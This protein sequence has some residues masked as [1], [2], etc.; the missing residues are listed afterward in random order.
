MPTSDF[1]GV[2]LLLPFQRDLKDDF[3]NGN[4]DPLFKSH[5]LLVLGI[6]AE[7][8]VADGELEWRTDF[9]SRFYLLRQQRN[10][11]ALQ[12]LAEF[13]AREA[14]DN[15]LPEFQLRSV[16][17]ARQIIDGRDVGVQIHIGFDPPGMASTSTPDGKLKVAV[18][19]SAT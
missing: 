1:S 8:E 3:A 4:G 16:S 18:N 14:F 6:D 10:T 9:G 5:V 2:G 11:I 13:Y 12:A 15:W 7:S 19:I 17:A